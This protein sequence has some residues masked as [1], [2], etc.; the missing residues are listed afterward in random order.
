[1]TATRSRTR[2]LGRTRKFWCRP[3]SPDPIPDAA[4]VWEDDVLIHDPCDRP[5]ETRIGQGWAEYRSTCWECGKRLVGTEVNHC[6]HGCEG[7]DVPVEDYEATMELVDR[8]IDR[9]GEVAAPLFR[10]GSDSVP[11]MVVLMAAADGLAVGCERRGRVHG[12]Q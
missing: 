1:M 2:V 12:E 5:V 9:A 6:A 3:C 11:Y 10:L 7:V 8:I 4:L